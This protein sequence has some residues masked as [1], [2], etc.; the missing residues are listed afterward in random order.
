MTD[1]PTTPPRIPNGPQILCRI[2]GEISN[3]VT[4]LCATH[5]DPDN[6]SVRVYLTAA[7]R[8]Y[9]AWKRDKENQNG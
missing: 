5:R 4:L 8:A 2:C 9:L 7:D 3:H 6:L 1:N